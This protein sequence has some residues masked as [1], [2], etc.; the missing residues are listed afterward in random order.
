[1]ELGVEQVTQRA[2]L[3]GYDATLAKLEAEAAITPTCTAAALN[4]PTQ[5]CNASAEA[6]DTPPYIV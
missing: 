4:S 2:T 3:A 1:M 5:P 6:S